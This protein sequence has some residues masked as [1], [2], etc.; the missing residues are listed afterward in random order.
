MLVCCG[1]GRCMSIYKPQ[2]RS[3]WH[4]EFLGAPDLVT[5]SWLEEF[6]PISLWR[7]IDSQERLSGLG[8]TLQNI[9]GLLNI[10]GWARSLGGHL[11]PHGDM[12]DELA[13]GDAPAFIMIQQN[14]IRDVRHD[15]A[16]RWDAHVIQDV[17]GR[18]VNVRKDGASLFAE[19]ASK[20]FYVAEEARTQAQW[21]RCV[22]LRN[23]VRLSM[24]NSARRST[25]CA[26]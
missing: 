16:T 18:W 23:F 3:N 11:V 4:F 26:N 24:R 15:I 17:E 9:N 7:L 22:F 5:L 12:P 14:A 8:V 20:P 13:Q 21:P 10:V 2:K 19:D 1:I 6:K 25:R